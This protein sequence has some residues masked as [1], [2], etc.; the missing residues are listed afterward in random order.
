V[1]PLHTV[2]PIGLILFVVVQPNAAVC[3]FEAVV[4]GK[5]FV[6]LCKEKE[7]AFQMYDQV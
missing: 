2:K 1:V 3:A 4:N 6:G 7:Q 5:K